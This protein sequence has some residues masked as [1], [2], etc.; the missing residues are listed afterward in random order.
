[1]NI[2]PTDSATPKSLY[3]GELIIRV[4]FVTGTF[5]ALVGLL[6]ISIAACAPHVVA[7]NTAPQSLEQEIKRVEAEI[8]RI[9]ADTLKQLPSIP[10]DT[11]HRMRR[12]QTL[13]KLELFD[14]QL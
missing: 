3:R 6:I 13:G 8:D 7:Q 11:A 12:V 2:A 9:L 14:K 10:D 5:A 4:A 1:M